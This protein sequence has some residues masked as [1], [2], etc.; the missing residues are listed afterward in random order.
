MAIL[1]LIWMIAGASF[2]TDKPWPVTGVGDAGPP[3]LNGLGTA[4]SLDDTRLRR[5]IR[6]ELASRGTP[7]LGADGQPV[8][9]AG[10]VRNP[11]D[12]QFRKERVARQ[13]DHYKRV[14]AIS[15]AQM[16]DLQQEI[17]R[18]DRASQ[19]EALSQLMRALNSRQ[20]DGRF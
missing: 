13:L 15:P 19:K 11:V 6:E 16:Q 14:G 5:I 20:I 10:K 7:A 3:G 12:D 4:G 8:S 18:M 17:A 1:V 2:D 9:P